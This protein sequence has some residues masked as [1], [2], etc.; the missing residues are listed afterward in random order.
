[1]PDRARRLQWAVVL[2]LWAVAIG[3]LVTAAGGG[4]G[5]LVVCGV[6]GWAVCLD[7]PRPVS[8]LVWLLFLGLGAA[9]AGLGSRV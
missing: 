8:A 5:P 1:M 3:V 6:D 4:F 2:G 7:W 9:L